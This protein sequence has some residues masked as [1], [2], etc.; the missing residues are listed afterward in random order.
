LLLVMKYLISFGF[1]FSTICHAQQIVDPPAAYYTNLAIA[2]SLAEQK[3]FD[4]A[5]HH[6]ALAFKSFDGRGAPADIYKAARIYALSEKPDSAFILAERLVKQEYINYIKLSRDPAFDV[7]RKHDF[8]RFTSL[9]NRLKA[10]KEKIAPAQNLKW[11]N[12]LDSIYESDQG[13]RVK[14][15]KVAQAQGWDSPEAKKFLPQMRVSDSLNHIAIT[16]FIDEHGWLGPDVVGEQGNMVLF[17]VIQHA[18]SATQEKYIPLLRKA[19]KEN[20]AK[21]ANLALM[22]DRLSISKYGYQIYGSQIM[23]DQWTKEMILKTI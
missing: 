7:L 9:V 6:Y 20:K 17:L 3:H 21:A 15:M 14:F 1:L 5:S 11:T 2:D 16:E 4:R 10:N 19:V 13:I 23:Q 8:P 18:D 22:E 12:F